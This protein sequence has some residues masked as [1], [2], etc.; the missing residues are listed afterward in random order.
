MYF[1]TF[2]VEGT[3]SSVGTG[4]GVET[5]GTCFILVRFTEK[6]SRLCTF[7]S[8]K[9]LLSSGGFDDRFLTLLFVVSGVAT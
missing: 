6:T 7:D 8:G 9:L 3:G 5:C 2:D 1:S 4:S